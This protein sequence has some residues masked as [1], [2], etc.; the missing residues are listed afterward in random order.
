MCVEK[1][2]HLINSSCM[3]KDPTDY[4]IKL[5]HRSVHCTLLW[6]AEHMTSWMG[7]R[8][9]HKSRF[10]IY[11][12]HGPRTWFTGSVP[13]ELLGG[14]AYISFFSEGAREGIGKFGT[15]PKSLVTVDV[16]NTF[17]VKIRGWKVSIFYRYYSPEKL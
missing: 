2:L 15:K 14:G 4:Y 5:A 1:G 8:R 7:R 13:N 6:L 10:I 11:Q 12:N 16:G 17:L 3:R 9:H